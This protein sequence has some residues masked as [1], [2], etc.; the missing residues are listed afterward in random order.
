MVLRSGSLRVG[1][2]HHDKWGREA[3][4]KAVR[5]SIT[6]IFHSRTRDRFTGRENPSAGD[7]NK[8]MLIV[9]FLLVV[10]VHFSSC[11]TIAVA[12]LVPFLSLLY[13]CTG[14]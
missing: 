7:T 1:K 2:E 12:N 11:L 5:V 4:E 13:E 3:V 14:D 8:Q 10:G 9:C 6:C